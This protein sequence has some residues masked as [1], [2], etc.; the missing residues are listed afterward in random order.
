MKTR[1]E[2][3]RA[4]NTAKAEALRFIERADDAMRQ[5]RGAHSEWDCCSTAYASA[6]RSSMDLTRSLVAVR[7]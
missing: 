1:E 5:L 6:K 3:I 4:L 7:R 2:K